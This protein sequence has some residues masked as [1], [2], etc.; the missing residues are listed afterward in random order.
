MKILLLGPP[1]GGKG[2]QAKFLI[3]KL[4]IP[5]NSLPQV[6]PSFSNFGEMKEIIPGVPV[7]AILGDQQAALFGQN[8]INKGDVKN[9][10]GCTKPI[11]GLKSTK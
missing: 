9:T 8:C 11:S 7:T 10:Y 4:N 2:T 1:G 3:E 6:K 5:I